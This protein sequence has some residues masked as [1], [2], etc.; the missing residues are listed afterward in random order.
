MSKPQSK[1]IHALDQD[2][3]EVFAVAASHEVT[4]REHGGDS[5]ESAA[6]EVADAASIALLPPAPTYTTAFYQSNGI[7]TCNTCGEKYRTDRHGLP[8]CPV[9]AVDCPRQP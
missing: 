7:P 6:E 1:K 3:M 8:L 4:S 9:D 5:A 2:E